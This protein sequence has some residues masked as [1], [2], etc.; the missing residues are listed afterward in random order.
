MS[1]NKLQKLLRARR[2]GEYASLRLSD[3]VKST[4]NASTRLFQL[5]SGTRKSKYT[6]NQ[7]HRKRTPGKIEGIIIKLNKRLTLIPSAKYLQNASE[8]NPNVYDLDC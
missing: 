4:G 3:V 7:K 8:E 5:A 1:R 6:Q 2:K